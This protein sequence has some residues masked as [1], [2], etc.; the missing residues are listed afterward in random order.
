MMMWWESDQT[1]ST[2]VS[3]W[4]LGLTILFGLGEL[5]NLYLT[6]VT[7][8]DD[9][10]YDADQV[11]EEQLSSNQLVNEILKRVEAHLSTHEVTIARDLASRMSRVRSPGTFFI[12]LLRSKMVA[13]LLGVDFNRLL[14]H[15]RPPSRHV[16]RRRRGK[17]LQKYVTGR[18]VASAISSFD[19]EE[20]HSCLSDD[21]VSTPPE[22]DETSSSAS[23]SDQDSSSPPSS[24]EE[25]AD[26]GALSWMRRSSSATC[27]DDDD[28]RAHS[29]SNM[30]SPLSK[31]DRP[32][33]SR[34]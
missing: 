26:E 25:G 10:D 5:Y 18:H 9:E 20:F 4:S 8:I 27:D 28:G 19:S 3:E 23:A 12:Q 13:S 29:S 33:V 34:E 2:R 14:L 17:A 1:G 15:F 24:S 30:A 22:S 16:R 32:S 11:E 31:S 7:G 6:L 21:G